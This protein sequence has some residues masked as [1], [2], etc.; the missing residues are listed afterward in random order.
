MAV[1]SHKPD[2][3]FGLEMGMGTIKKLG[4]LKKPW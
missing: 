2:P 4:L 3:M 1:A